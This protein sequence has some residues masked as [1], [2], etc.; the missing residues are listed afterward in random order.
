M[1][2]TIDEINKKIKKGEAVVLTA[3][4]VKEMAS[5]SGIKEVA[6]KVDVVTT[7][8]FGPMCSS[9]AFIN[10]GHTR[11]GIRMAKI[12]LNDVPA[13]AGLA[14]VDA[15]IG[16]TEL[17]ETDPNYGGAHII[18]DL[19]KGKDIRLKAIGTG[20]DCY[21][22]KTVET[23]INK[24]NINECFLFNPRNAYQNYNAATNSSKKTLYTYMGILLP[25]FGNVTYSTTGELSPLLNDPGLRTIGIGTRIFLGGTQGYVAWNGTQFNTTTARNRKG[26]PIGPSAT[27][28]LIGNLKKMKPE[29][30]KP[31]IFEHYGISLFVGIGVPIPVLDQEIAR[32]VSIRDRKIETL[33]CDY[34]A[35][36]HPPIA[37]VSYEELKSGSIVINNRKIKTGPLSSIYVARRIAKVLKRWIVSGRFLLSEPVAPLPRRSRFKHLIIR[38]GGKR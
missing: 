9:G 6:K 24:D 2:K 31:A 28:A 18:E 25:N 10:F 13:Y 5:S 37:R 16:A 33:L 19:I 17:S 35:E 32:A 8:T 21:P 12:W 3:E 14:A 38:K 26:I 7:A 11:P 22:R 23:Y 4:E 30:I 15:Y 36:G 20:T 34:G 29:Y 27:L 1:P